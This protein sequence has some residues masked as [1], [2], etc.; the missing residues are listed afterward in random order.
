VAYHFVRSPGPHTSGVDVSDPS[1]LGSGKADAPDPSP[2]G[3]GVADAPDPSPLGSGVADAPDPLP[4]GSGEA[5]VSFTS[6]SHWV[7]G[8][9]SPSGPLAA[10]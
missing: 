4:L 1:S 8:G 10:I 2:L 7:V 3:S 9:P 5:A 6:A